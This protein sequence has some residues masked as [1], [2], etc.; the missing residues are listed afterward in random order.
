MAA[1]QIS[2][3]NATINANE[4]YTN[5][6]DL[7]ASFVV[8]LIMP[9]DWDNAVASIVVSADGDNYYDLFDPRGGEF[10]FNVIK[11]AMIFVDHEVFLMAKYMKLRSG[12]RDN[13]IPQ[14][15]LRRFTFILT[16]TVSSIATKEP[17][18]DT[19]DR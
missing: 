15:V 2:T 19:T 9:D 8:G 14:S 16:G 10:T 11:G 13:E 6:V 17:E 7:T 1:P 3:L 5:V 18:H 12:T 4:A